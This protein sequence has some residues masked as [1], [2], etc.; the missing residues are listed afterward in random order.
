MR[1]MVQYQPDLQTAHGAFRC[2]TLASTDLRVVS[3]WSAFGLALSILFFTLGF[4]AQIGEA[5]SAAG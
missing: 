5:L 2:D 1:T 4:G 3:L